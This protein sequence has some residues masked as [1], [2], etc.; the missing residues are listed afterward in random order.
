MR[1]LVTGVK[2]QLGHDLAPELT[3]RNHAVIGTDLAPNDSGA[4]AYI[5]LD[6]TDRDAVQKVIRE[7]KPDAV[8]HC[9]AWTN[10]DAAEAEENRARAEAV[11]HWGTKYIAA[12]AK[13]ADAK[14]LYLSTDYVF[15]G[16]GETP[17]KPDE[18]HDAPLNVYGQTKLAGEIA[19][20]NALDRFFIVRTAWMFGANGRNFVK[21]M[22]RLG[23]TQGS[24][25]VVNDQ[26]GTPTYT[27]D[28]AR[29]LSDMIETDR[30]GCYHATNAGGYISWYDFT[31]EIYRQAGLAAAVVPISTAEYGLSKARRPLNA[32]LD[33][34][35]LR[36][37]G[38]VPL[39]LWQDAL[40]RYLKETGLE[41]GSNFS[42]L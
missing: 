21:T 22:L 10:V 11:N 2:G 4:S 16:E 39:P 33:Q 6:I 7:I 35:K 3:R 23:G 28:L 9:A 38:F 18:T 40:E 15:S 8:V 42:D 13:A 31:K 24:V 1:I 34:S 36:E 5:P 17:W 30:Y 25:R 12:A 27:K 41:N 37:A 32:R 29:L 26:I 19:V 20:R 14:L